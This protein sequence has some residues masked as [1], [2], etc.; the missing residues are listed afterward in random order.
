[1]YSAWGCRWLWCQRNKTY[2]CHR[3]CFV[4]SYAKREHPCSAEKTTVW[5]FAN[6]RKCGKTTGITDQ[7][8]CLQRKKKVEKQGMEDERRVWQRD[9]KRSAFLYSLWDSQVRGRKG[10]LS[11]SQSHFRWDPSLHP[12]YLGCVCACVCVFEQEK[13]KEREMVS[14]SLPGDMAL[15]FTDRSAVTTTSTSGAVTCHC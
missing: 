1:M 8:N 13:E 5:S 11:I 9:L 6:G 15:C 10:R 2:L 14:S 7:T 3:S 12:R 4:S